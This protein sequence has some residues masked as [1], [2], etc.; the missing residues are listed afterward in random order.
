MVILL[1]H[2]MF[3]EVRRHLRDNK[4]FGSPIKY[5]LRPTALFTNK[6]RWAFFITLCY[7][8]FYDVNLTI[9]PLDRPRPAEFTNFP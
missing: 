8:V 6:A 5:T 7:I 3:N 4:W 9:S 2:Y 1:K